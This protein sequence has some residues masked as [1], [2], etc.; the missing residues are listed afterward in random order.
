MK[1][2]MSSNRDC[3]VDVSLGTH[4]PFVCQWILFTNRSIHVSRE[5]TND[6]AGLCCFCIIVQPTLVLLRYAIS[7]PTAFSLPLSIASYLLYMVYP[8][9]SVNFR[10]NIWRVVVRF[11]ESSWC[12]LCF[13]ID[14]LITYC[15]IIVLSLFLISI[16][17]CCDINVGFCLVL[18]QS[19]AFRIKT[20]TSSVWQKFMYL[21]LY[22]II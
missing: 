22:Y 12:T 3:C 17:N 7:D 15:A 9:V 4:D 14:N 21:S 2:L 19:S 8:G 6:H 5:L 13:F 16:K 10:Q 18:C 11:H 1:Q 20:D